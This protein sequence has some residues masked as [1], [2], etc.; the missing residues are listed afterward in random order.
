[1]INNCVGLIFEVLKQTLFRS[2][3]H[4]ALLF[5]IS[6]FNFFKGE[7]VVKPHQQSV[8][9]LQAKLEQQD[10]MSKYNLEEKRL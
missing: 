8:T 9:W 10:N 5:N 4:H 7:I 3:V 6:R 2:F 1:M